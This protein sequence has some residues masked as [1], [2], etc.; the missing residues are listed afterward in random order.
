MR[1]VQNYA[2]MGVQGVKSLINEFMRSDGYLHYGLYT[3]NRFGVDEDVKRLDLI[4]YHTLSTRLLLRIANILR[5]EELF[6]YASK[7]LRYSLNRLFNGFKGIGAELLRCL[8]EYYRWYRDSQILRTIE[9]VTVDGNISS[10]LLGY[11]P[12]ELDNLSAIPPATY[13]RTGQASMLLLNTSNN[14]YLYYVYSF[15]PNAVVVEERML[16]SGRPIK[17]LNVECKVLGDE[18]DDACNI[19]KTE[20][21][22]F[23]ASI[24]LRIHAEEA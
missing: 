22:G 5:D 14:S 20:K 18:D 4:G 23:D 12:D 24:L 10:L 9:S 6:S 2:L 1:L 11:T 17:S 15:S 13:L 16:P 19:S 3:K 8:V 21:K 7:A